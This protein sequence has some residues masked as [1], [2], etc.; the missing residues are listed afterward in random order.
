MQYNSHKIEYYVYKGSLPEISQKISNSINSATDALIDKLPYEDIEALLP[1]FQ[2][3]LPK[4][5]SNMA[6]DK[7]KE[8]VP[9]QYVVNAIASCLASKMVYE[10]QYCGAAQWCLLV[11]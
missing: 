4:T 3:H 11:L 2:E 6:F 5:L 10:G 7:V 8:V 1:L 9:D